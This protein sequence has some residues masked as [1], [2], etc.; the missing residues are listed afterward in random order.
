[1]A[2]RVA[3]RSLSE[4]AAVAE[5]VF[6][7]KGYRATGISDVSKALGLSHGAIYTYV[8]S[9]EALLYIALVKVIRPDQL[10]GMVIPVKMPP[11]DE[12]VRLARLWADV[13]PFPALAGAITGQVVGSVRDEF[14]AIVDEL[15]A[16]I[17]GNRNT[18]GLVAQCARELPEMFQYWFVQRRRSH[19]EALST[20]LRARIEAGQLRDVPDVPTAARFIVET[21][22]WFAW[23]RLGDP[24]SPNLTDDLARVTVHHLLPNAFL[25]SEGDTDE[26]DRRISQDDATG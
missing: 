19:F 16:F 25:P 10:D 4:I 12:V 11:E 2:G 15:Y 18:L 21:I 8:Q 5:Y 1:M 23:H 26:R 14:V 24:D 9:K 3:A 22:A 7:R 6:T 17:E 20:Y 13:N